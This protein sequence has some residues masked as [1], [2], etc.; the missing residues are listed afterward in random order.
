MVAHTDEL[1]VE[2]AHGKG[3]HLG[4]VDAAVLVAGKAAVAGPFPEAAPAHQGEDAHLVAKIVHRV[5]QAPDILEADAVQPHILHQLQLGPG[6]LRGVFHKVIVCPAAGLE[7]DLLP[8]HIELAMTQGI[9]LT[10]YAPEAEG[11]VLGVR[12][13]EAHLKVI[14]LRSTHIVGPPD[15]GILHFFLLANDPGFTGLQAHFLRETAALVPAFQGAGN[16]FVTAVHQSG[17]HLDGGLRQVLGEEGF[18]KHVLHLHIRGANESNGGQDAH[19]IVQGEGIPVHKTVVQ[20]APRGLVRAN[21]QAVVLFQQRGNVPFPYGKDAQGG[22]GAGEEGSVHQDIGRI[23]QS[24]HPEDVVSLP[25]FETGGEH[26]GAVEAGLVQLKEVQLLQRV[27]PQLT[28]PVQGTGYGGGNGYGIRLAAAYLLHFPLREL[29]GAGG[30]G[31]S[32]GHEG[33]GKEGY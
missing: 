11:G 15:A 29:P 17:I 2:I 7:Q 5:V 16:G 10:G 14:Q 28:G 12:M 13:S 19:K 25:G 24:A 4:T 21:F 9:Y 30:A 8:I 20:A 31:A 1:V 33:G 18:H 27:L 22:I 6:A 3:L 23:T 26:P 32:G